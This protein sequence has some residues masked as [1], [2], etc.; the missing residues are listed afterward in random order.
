MGIRVED[1]KAKYP[2][3]VRYGS[4]GGYCVG[5]ALGLY[6]MREHGL[7]H[8]WAQGFPTLTALTGYLKVANPLLDEELAA[9][10]G[11]GILREND[12]GTFEAA[13]ELLRQA[14]VYREG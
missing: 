10:Y 7:L 3:P 2:S 11:G 9:R 6:L 5:G 13:W 12:L 8:G 1:I 14:L 4:V